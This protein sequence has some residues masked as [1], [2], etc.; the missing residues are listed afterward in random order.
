MKKMFV[1]VMAMLFLL[2]AAGC[3]PL[4]I[5]LP[6]QSASPTPVPTI[7]PTPTPTL[8]PT[9]PPTPA[10]TPTPTLAPTPTPFGETPEYLGSGDILFDLYINKALVDLNKDGTPEEVE[11]IAGS[12]SSEL[13]INGT[14]Y[15]VNVSHL[16]QMFG[17]TDV[18]TTDNTLELVFTDRYSSGLADSEKAYSYLYWW[19][20]TQILKMGS[21][22]DVKFAGAWKAGFDPTEHFDGKGMVMCLART[23]EFSDVWYTGHYLAD[24][25]SRKLKEDGYSTKPINEQS[26]MTLKH[27]CVLLK[28]IDSKYF[29]FDYSVIWDDAS[30]YATLDRNYT[31]DIVSFIP[32]EGEQL[33]II[34]VYGQ[35]WFKLQAADG[36]S[37]WLKCVDGKVQGYYQVMNIVASDIFDGI[38]IAG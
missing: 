17:I 22:M 5:P 8:A 24:G 21:L 35:Y 20:G 27:Y 30:G 26:A 9:P 34:R 13:H 23:E 3:T 25:T 14:S 37:G 19:N 36:K 15:P 12:S 16:A 18:D 31:D 11:F 38:L 29:G 10:P 1:L 6:T 2:S 33:K 4:P 32:R 28:K 7:A